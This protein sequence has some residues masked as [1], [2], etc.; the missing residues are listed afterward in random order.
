MLSRCDSLSSWQEKFDSRF[1][2]HN[3]SQ[4]RVGYFFVVD[5]MLGVRGGKGTFFVALVQLWAL[6][7]ISPSGFVRVVTNM[8]DTGVSFLSYASNAF[9]GFIFGSYRFVKLPCRLLP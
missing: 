6:A 5:K 1:W 2:M 8:H 4:C 7:I 3:I 9:L